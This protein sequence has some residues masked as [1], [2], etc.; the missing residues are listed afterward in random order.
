MREDDLDDASEEF[1]QEMKTA[2]EAHQLMLSSRR[3]K[4]QVE[5]AEDDPLEPQEVTQAPTPEF[6]PP[7]QSEVPK[8]LQT[9]L[10]RA[11]YHPSH[12]PRKPPRERY[13]MA[14]RQY[15]PSAF[16]IQSSRPVRHRHLKP[17]EDHRDKR[18]T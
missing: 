4:T 5:I 6:V 1:K 3:K 8:A 13:V 17:L 10:G 18:H 9:D 11:Y 2:Q 14:L 7:D 12:N 15:W 16:D